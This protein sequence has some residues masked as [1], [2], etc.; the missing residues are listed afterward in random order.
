MEENATQSIDPIPPNARRLM[1]RALAVG[2]VACLFVEMRP[3][4]F[5]LDM[6][7]MTIFV[8]LM[9][10]TVVLGFKALIAMGSAQNRRK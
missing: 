1:A 4:L 2:V 10:Y 7:C 6:A 3:G 8:I 9:F 5:W